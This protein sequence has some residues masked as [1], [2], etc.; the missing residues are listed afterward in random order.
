MKL[1]EEAELQ[2]KKKMEALRASVLQ[3]DIEKAKPQETEDEKQ[4]KMMNDDE[5]T[6]EEKVSNNNNNYFTT[7]NDSR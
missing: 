2:K 7:T 3:D 5:M 6:D 4:A 1:D